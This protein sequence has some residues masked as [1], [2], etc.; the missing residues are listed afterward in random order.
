MYVP[1]TELEYGPF[2]GKAFS[3]LEGIPQTDSVVLLED[4]NAHVGK[5]AQTWKDVFGKNCDSDSNVQGRLPLDFRTGGG[6]SIMDIF[7]PHNDIHR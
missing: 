7:F 3:V 6:L 4:F 1:N 2:L 5:D